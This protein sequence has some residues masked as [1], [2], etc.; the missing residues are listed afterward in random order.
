MVTREA[1]RIIDEMADYWKKNSMTF[2]E[3]KA[4]ECASKSLEKNIPQTI[5]SD[6]NSLVWCPKCNQILNFA[7]EYC[8]HCG[9]KLMKE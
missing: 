1:K 3:L 6:K 8:N 5:Q 4:L 2:S 9:Q 7:D